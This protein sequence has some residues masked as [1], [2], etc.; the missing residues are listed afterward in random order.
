MLCAT[1]SALP[2][3]LTAMTRHVTPRALH[4]LDIDNLAITLLSHG[5]PDLS[6]D[7][8]ANKFPS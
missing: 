7:A 2:F 3:I 6:W 4:G 1:V 5:V 8:E